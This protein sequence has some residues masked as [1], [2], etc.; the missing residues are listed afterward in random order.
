MTPA[1]TQQ[2]EPVVGVGD[3]EAQPLSS[4]PAVHHQRY[5]SHAW[6]RFGFYYYSTALPL[7]TNDGYEDPCCAKSL[8]T[9][10]RTWEDGSGEDGAMQ[11]SAGKQKKK[12]LPVQFLIKSNILLP[13]LYAAGKRIYCKR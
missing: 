2:G 3:P 6:H 1:L 9:S 5:D 8:L 11:M 4:S 7:I 10:G 13:D 12:T